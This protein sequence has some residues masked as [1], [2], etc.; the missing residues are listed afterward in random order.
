MCVYSEQMDEELSDRKETQ[1]LHG[2]L[3]GYVLYHTARYALY[4]LY[5]YTVKLIH[6]LNYETLK[7]PL[8]SADSCVLYLL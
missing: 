3:H 7:M 6:F 1:Y 5:V 4:I 8:N 2:D